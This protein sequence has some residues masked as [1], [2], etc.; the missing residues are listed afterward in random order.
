MKKNNDNLVF[1]SVKKSTSSDFGIDE[2][3]ISISDQQKI[4]I[5][6]IYADKKRKYSD[7][8]S[9][10]D[11]VDYESISDE[12]LKKFSQQTGADNI[13]Y[14]LA[15]Q[16][17][18]FENI[19]I[20][21]KINLAFNDFFTEKKEKSGLNRVLKEIISQPKKD[22]MEKVR[23]EIQAVKQK[24]A[25]KQNIKNI[26]RPI[27]DKSNNEI[28]KDVQETSGFFSKIT[29]RI[30]GFFSIKPA[31]TRK[32]NEKQLAEDLNTESTPTEEISKDIASQPNNEDVNKD[33]PK[34]EAKKEEP[35]LKCLEFSLRRS[36]SRCG[37]CGKILESVD[38][39]QIG[40]LE[41]ILS[42]HKTI[43]KI[44]DEGG[45][46]SCYREHLHNTLQDLIED[47]LIDIKTRYYGNEAFEPYDLYRELGEI[48]TIK[49]ELLKKDYLHKNTN[50]S[51]K[52][53]ETKMQR[54]T[55]VYNKKCYEHMDEKIRVLS[56]VLGKFLC[57]PNGVVPAITSSQIYLL[58]AHCSQL[59]LSFYI[60]ENISIEEFDFYSKKQTL[61]IID[62]N[63][64]LFKQIHQT[65][66]G[67]NP[68]AEQK[69]LVSFMV[70]ENLLKLLEEDN[71]IIAI[72]ELIK[73]LS[74]KSR[75]I[76]NQD[77]QENCEQNSENNLIAAD[78]EIE[79]PHKKDRSIFLSD[80]FNRE[81][82][83]RLEKFI[84][85][86]TKKINKLI[87]GDLDKK[88]SLKQQREILIEGE[89]KKSSIKE[90][91]I[92]DEIE[93]HIISAS[94]TFEKENL[95]KKSKKKDERIEINNI[96][97]RNISS[98]TE[99]LIEKIY[100]DQKQWINEI[101]FN[102]LSPYL[103]NASMNNPNL[104]NSSLKKLYEEA[105]D[106]LF[107]STRNKTHLYQNNAVDKNQFTNE[108][109]IWLD[110]KLSYL[111]SVELNRVSY[112][113]FKS[114]LGTL[115]KNKRGDT[116]KYRRKNPLLV[117]F[118]QDEKDIW[119]ENLVKNRDNNFVTKILN[120][121]ENDLPK[122]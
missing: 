55:D 69:K 73:S 122:S 47:H 32:I 85:F 28:K 116:R 63:L 36:G 117:N 21:K 79:I 39:N 72:E 16:Y 80:L 112:A 109:C 31:I 4:L 42:Y 108:F 22:Q 30:T 71:E 66:D 11:K 50:D 100:H 90:K 101:D 120:I 96:F 91:F 61:Y 24:N 57:Q 7:V 6:V 102:I 121:T 94:K 74:E 70:E 53:F 2:K 51:E 88:Y 67:L 27:S 58:K 17:K 9:A 41:K 5:T 48:Y 1:A 119:L 107:L 68:N 54:N 95:H 78:S 3:E 99:E 84:I 111:V 93:K 105:M 25:D 92:S 65:V 81:E 59:A 18:I 44:D 77:G 40:N 86:V 83:K 37:N 12:Y 43:N 23:K 64:D 89:G 76:I 60:D 14:L 20:Q 103:A 56:S 97:V 115:P 62:S 26:T 29:R 52:D 46:G 75:D 118:Q 45:I 110:K 38:L 114:F 8:F 49:Y 35:C 10:K 15:N 87:D 106:Y 82:I 19:E 33:N 34:K 98:I 13:D 113:E 104:P